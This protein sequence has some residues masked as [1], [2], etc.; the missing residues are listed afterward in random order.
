MGHMQNIKIRRMPRKVKDHLRRREKLKKKPRRVK[1]WSI[2][3]R[4][5]DYYEPLPLLVGDQ[6]K[7]QKFKGRYIKK[8]NGQIGTVFQIFGANLFEVLLKVPDDKR[9]SNLLVEKK[10]RVNSDQIAQV[11]SPK[12]QD[13]AFPSILIKQK[14][15]Y[16][17]RMSNQSYNRFNAIGVREKPNEG[18]KRTGKLVGAKRATFDVD[19]VMPMD[20][21]QTYLHLADG[22]GWV[23]TQDPTNYDETIAICVGM[24]ME[25]YGVT[26]KA[27]NVSLNKWHAAKFH[28]VPLQ[29]IEENKPGYNAELDNKNS[30]RD[31][32][33]GL[34]LVENIAKEF[35]FENQQFAKDM[36]NYGP[37]V[38]EKLRAKAKS[39]KEGALKKL[40]TEIKAFDFKPGTANDGA[41]AK[42]LLEE[43][44]KINDIFKQARQRRHERVMKEQQ[45]A[46]EQGLM[47][48]P[49]DPPKQ[50]PAWRPI[51]K[52]K[53]EK[54]K[55]DARV[56]YGRARRF[57]WAKEREEHKK[58]S[59][60]RNNFK[61]KL[62]AR[63]IDPRS[64]KVGYHTD[65]ASRWEKF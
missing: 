51:W 17:Y 15:I 42:K 65:R 57:A 47:R 13:G 16:T 52:E 39:R 29:M 46:R 41:F 34:R 14:Q 64:K 37:E 19:R 1:P 28:N 20:N 45:T 2:T 54:A 38:V 3:K 18:S 60:S 12:R 50:P 56:A 33:R 53:I 10:V 9:D 26:N 55:R 7:L 24:R 43:T 11:Y 62:R 31:D 8:F 59:F 6:V 25:N 36:E 58:N 61:E 5:R 4:R 49:A 23:F 48:E 32:T 21:G 44:K 27:A 30:K 40:E 63:G 22:S 35:A